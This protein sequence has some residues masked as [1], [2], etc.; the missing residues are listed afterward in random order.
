MGP[1]SL[2]VSN[3]AQRGPSVA[4][5][6]AQ[7]GPNVAPMW[8]QC[9]EHSPMWPASAAQEASWPRL[10]RRHLGASAQRSAT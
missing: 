2:G 8:P 4:P 6:W 10:A 9:V 5:V 3:T 1:P 7:R